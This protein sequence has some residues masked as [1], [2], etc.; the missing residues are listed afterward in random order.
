MNKNR[1]E[2]LATRITTWISQNPEDVFLRRDF[3]E[4]GSY[5]QVG[6][7]LQKLLAKGLLVRIGYGIY[8]KTAISSLSGQVIPCRGLPGI[9]REALLRLGI[10]VFPSFC[11]QAYNEDRTTQVPTGRVIGVKKRVTRK[12]GYNGMYV[13]YEKVNRPS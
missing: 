10:E 3:N 13:I 1:L 5:A 2:P 7:V 8:V 12:I 9:A 4:F 11:E 6:K